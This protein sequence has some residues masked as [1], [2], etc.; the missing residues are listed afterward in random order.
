MK[1]KE[2]L[3]HVLTFGS[4]KRTQKAHKEER[5]VFFSTQ[6]IDP[7]L[8]GQKEGL[9][10]SIPTGPGISRVATSRR[11]V[12]VGGIHKI[13][14]LVPRVKSRKES[15]AVLGRG[16]LYVVSSVQGKAYPFHPRGWLRQQSSPGVCG[17]PVH[18]VVPI[19]EA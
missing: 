13:S 7:G 3:F 11:G 9:L 19:Q 15:Q 1:F 10:L 8:F 18:Y 2:F 17:M 4:E 16:C 12:G 6:N 14:S 5:E